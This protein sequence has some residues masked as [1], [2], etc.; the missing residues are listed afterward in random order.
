MVIDWT[1]SEWILHHQQ[2]V[3]R[4]DY[5]AMIG[6]SFSNT[7][8]RGIDPE[9][10]V[11]FFFWSLAPDPEFFFPAYLAGTQAGLLI[12]DP[13]TTQDQLR[14]GIRYFH[15]APESFPVVILAPMN[16]QQAWID[17]DPAILRIEDRPEAMTAVEDRFIAL[18]QHSFSD[19]A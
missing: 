13:T 18:I 19:C 10:V 16:C 5:R 4:N 7:Q 1:R 14:E 9:H 11:T 15:T 2:P 8:P 12:L 17:Q 3:Q 6:I